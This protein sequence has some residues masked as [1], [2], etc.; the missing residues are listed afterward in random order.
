M[1]R[2][3]ALLTL[4]GR[5]YVTG[6]AVAARFL[7]NPEV[8]ILLHQTAPFALALAGWLAILPFTYSAV[9]RVRKSGFLPADAAVQHGWLAGI[10]VIALLWTLHVPSPIGIE[11]GLLGSALYAIVFGYSRALLGLF[12]AIG[13]HMLATGGSWVNFG[14]NALLLA[15]IPVIVAVTLQRAVARWLPIN[16]FVFIFGNGLAVTL[17]TTAVAGLLLNGAATLALG[18]GWQAAG[19]QLVFTLLLAWGEAMVSGMIFS[20]LVVF[21]P[22]AVLTYDQ[23]LYLPPR[24]A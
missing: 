24:R 17:I 16:L 1:D 5:V 12:T 21:L 9:S 20:S 22:R 4:I 11:F 23:D 7:R 18:Q 13:L 19:D 8:M 14:I 3:D 6:G 15:V 10:V 2:H